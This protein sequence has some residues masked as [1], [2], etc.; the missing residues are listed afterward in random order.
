[1]LE[2]STFIQT[3]TVVAP[4]LPSPPRTAVEPSPFLPVAYDR[5]KSG[6]VAL[7]LTGSI[8]QLVKALEFLGGARAPD[9][10]GSGGGEEEGEG[11][12][13]EG[14]RR[15]MERTAGPQTEWM[16]RQVVERIQLSA[17]GDLDS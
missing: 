16:A 5:R 9:V 6:P 2:F 1:M 15:G 14:D 10:A 11:G 12:G 3:Q 13:T 7:D 8:S 17:A 4:P